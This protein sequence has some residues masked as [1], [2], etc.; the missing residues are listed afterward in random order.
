LSWHQWRGVIDF[1]A[2]VNARILTSMATSQGVRDTSG[3]WTP[4]QAKRLIDFT[5]SGGGDI[6][7]AE[8]MNEPTMAA[9]GGAPKG[10]DAAASG[11]DFKLF[12]TFARQAA[13]DMRILGPG[14]VGETTAS[15]AMIHYG[16]QGT[17]ATR[18]M[19]QQMGK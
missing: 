8:F 11:R 14:S 6:A 9:M 5:R 10:Y 7:A 1:A 18:D 2:A 17:I 3:V 12:A 13:S 15:D 16:S 19:L 4:E